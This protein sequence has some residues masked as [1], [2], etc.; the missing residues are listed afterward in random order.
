MVLETTGTPRV[1][2]AHASGQNVGRL[3]RYASVA[4]GGALIVAGAKRR[5]LPGLV[6]A[7]LGAAL[8]ERGATGHCRMYDTLG[9][10]TRDTGGGE[11][12]HPAA[13]RSNPTAA[14]RASDAIKIEHRV[15]VD[16]PRAECYRM[17]HRFERLP[18]F[19]DHLISVRVLDETR[20]FWE[21]KAPLGRTVEWYAEIINEVPDELIA[22]KSVD[23]PDVKNA[24]SVHFTDA[25][26]GRGTEV[27]VT[28]DYAP[29]GGRVGAALA[30]LFGEN[31]DQQ[32][33]DDLRR[34][35]AIMEHGGEHG[36]SG[37]YAT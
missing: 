35:K 33:Q 29:P 3:E 4:G 13:T 15:V 9:V 36:G 2:D 11:L 30:R 22:W 25:V 37:A 5:D 31:P 17:W 1:P 34:F 20:S 28:L 14:L 19:M 23:D 10:T 6:M 32:V 8:L 27:R 26:G 18:E 24:G 12:P 21:A 16:R 7:L